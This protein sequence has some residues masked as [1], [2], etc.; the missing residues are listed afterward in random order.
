MNTKF[1]PWLII[2][3]LMVAL[4]LSLKTCQTNKDLLNQSNSSLITLNDTLTVYKNKKGLWEAKSSVVEM[5]DPLLFTKFKTKDTTLRD[6]QKLVK[7]NIKNINS[8][9][10]LT[11]ETN[12]TTKVPTKVTEYVYINDTIYPVY[13]GLID[14][15][16]WIL[17]SVLARKDSISTD[18]KVKNEYSV[19]VKKEKGV[20][21]AV[22]T[23]H[24]P[25]TQTKELK[26]FN[27]SVP[28]PS[29]IGL[30]ATVGYGMTID[31]DFKPF[32]GVGITYNILRF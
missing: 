29:K 30:G 14:K 3:V 15:E 27:V 25:Y 32:V 4:F 31:G 22:V 28:K 2:V 20:N 8:A 24:N 21:Y 9:T 12:V 11:T 13:Q 6:L 17:G 23:N 7:E 26:T 1:I 16:G 18:F 19:V 10:I 5:S